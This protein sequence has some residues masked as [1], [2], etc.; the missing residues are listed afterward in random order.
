MQGPLN[1]E[2][3]S[4]F[5]LLVH[6]GRP[7]KGCKTVIVVVWIFSGYHNHCHLTSVF[8]QSMFDIALH[9]YL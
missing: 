7:K 9:V 8:I 1:T 3:A 4:L 6:Q 5:L 2:M